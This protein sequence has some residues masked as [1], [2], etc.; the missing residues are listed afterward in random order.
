[1]SENLKGRNHLEDL[2]INERIISK[3][4]LE[5]QDGKLWIG[6]IWLSIGVSGRL[7]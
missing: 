2:R 6:L 1:V 3:C 4:I 5:K 7:L